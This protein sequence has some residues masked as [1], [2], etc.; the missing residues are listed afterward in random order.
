MLQKK[1]TVQFFFSQF[2]E[3]IEK[4]ILYY[5]ANQL[6]LLILLMSKWGEGECVALTH[7]VFDNF[8]NIFINELT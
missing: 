7:G 3:N 1:K 6:Q 8:Q 4:Y 2:F 5:C